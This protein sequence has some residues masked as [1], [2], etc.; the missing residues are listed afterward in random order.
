[1]LDR[2]VRLVESTPV[3]APLARFG[4]LI[5]PALS[6]HSLVSRVINFLLLRSPW[7]MRRLAAYAGRL[8]A[9]EVGSQSFQFVVTQAG[10]LAPHFQ[11]RQTV[12]VR[13]VLPTADWPALGAAVL[14][15][16]PEHIAEHLR[17]EGDVG[18]ARAL[19]EIAGQLHWDVEA[20]VAQ[21]TG[22]ILAV[23]LVQTFNGS[24]QW[25]QQ[26]AQ[27]IRDNIAEYLGHESGWLT[28][29][30]YVAFLSQRQQ[31]LEQLL[32][33]AEQRVAHIESV[34]G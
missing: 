7:A 20:E 5:P 22:D 19:A 11:G 16:Q 8:L 14:Q 28:H 30:D 2:L 31:Q 32:T 33:Q 23:R 13:L 18:F 9:I 34:S 10:L 25:I 26:C 24:A 6:P 15:Q 17:I 4:G 3:L 21:F 29:R 1:M 12:D 27:H